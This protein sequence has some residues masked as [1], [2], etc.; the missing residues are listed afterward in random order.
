VRKGI[1]PTSQVSIVFTGPIQNDEIHRLA[2][3]AMS[4]TLS[5]NLFATL[6]RDLGGTYGVTVEPRFSKRPNEEFRIAINFACDPARTDSL[7]RT[8]FQV[9]E[10]FKATGPSEDQVVDERSALLR[11]FETNSERNEYLLSR[12]L[13]KYQY[14]EDVRDVF[15]MRPYYDQLTGTLMRDAARTYLNTNRYVQVTLVPET[16]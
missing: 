13:Y 6:R 4:A 10:R 2:V 3:Q 9:I 1:E 8:T 5:G 15:N 7:I 12:L 11:D 16:K 14:G